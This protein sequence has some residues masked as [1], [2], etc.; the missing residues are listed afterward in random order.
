MSILFEYMFINV[1]DTSTGPVSVPH[2]T[3]P[4]INPPWP[5][6]QT[7]SHFNPRLILSLAENLAKVT[8]CYLLF[9]DF[10]IP[11][12]IILLEDQIPDW[13]VAIMQVKQYI[14]AK[15][16]AGAELYQA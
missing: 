4:H 11:D 16:N 15:Q 13:L 8:V 7:D 2:L 9:K 12:P 10:I 3:P 6:N 14:R 5:D 1:D